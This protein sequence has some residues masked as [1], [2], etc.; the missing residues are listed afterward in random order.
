[1]SARRFRHRDR[2]Q[3]RPGLPQQAPGG[4]PPGIRIRSIRHYAPPYTAARRF[5]LPAAYASGISDTAHHGHRVPDIRRT[6]D[7]GVRH[8]GLPAAYASGISDTA[9][10]GH[11]VPD[12]RRTPDTG[13]RHTGLPAAYASEIKY[14][15]FPTS[16][17]A[18]R[19]ASG[20]KKSDMKKGNPVS[21]SPSD[22]P[23]CARIPGGGAISSRAGRSTRAS[24]YRP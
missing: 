13:V 5:G 20:M 18:G 2:Q 9:H 8:T 22:A 1:M 24:T 23:C 3:V 12:I 11:R 14:P 19:L 16:G 21:D 6:P 4:A 15:V 7:T 17:A 10:H